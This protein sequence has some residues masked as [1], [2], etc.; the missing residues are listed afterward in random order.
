MIY[1]LADHI[2]RDREIIP[3][4]TIRKPPSAE[5][6]PNQKDTDSL[7]TYEVLDQILVNYI[8][9]NLTARQIIEKTGYDEKLVYEILRKVDRAE[10]KRKQFPIGLRITSKAFGFGRR[11][12]IAQGYEH[13]GSSDF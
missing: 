2:N 11:W 10:Y 5:L 9:E 8:E 3:I 1:K 7:P 6:R 4:N 13:S 12:P